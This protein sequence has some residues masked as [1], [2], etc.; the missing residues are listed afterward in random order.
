MSLDIV[1]A[2]HHIH[3][4]VI[5]FQ[6][7]TLLLTALASAGP[8]DHPSAWKPDFPLVASCST[9]SDSTFFADHQARKCLHFIVLPCH[10][11]LKTKACSRESAI[12]DREICFGTTFCKKGS[13]F[14]QN[15]LSIEKEVSVKHPNPTAALEMKAGR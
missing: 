11:S 15:V 12:N 13:P 9:S 4:C 14:L 1:M 10:S 5:S 6:F 8:F 3:I 2:Q 7:F